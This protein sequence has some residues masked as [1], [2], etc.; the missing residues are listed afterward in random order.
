[1]D[2]I[3]VTVT[4]KASQECQKALILQGLSGK[5][6][7][8]IVV[9]IPQSALTELPIS[10][11]TNGNASLK[12][13]EKH[14]KHYDDR[15]IDFT[16][17]CGFECDCCGKIIDHDYVTSPIYTYDDVVSLVTANEARLNTIKNKI[18]QDKKQKQLIAEIKATT[19]QE[20]EK[21][22]VDKYSNALNQIAQV[23]VV[24]TNKTRVRTSQIHN[25]IK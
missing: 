15:I 18:E 13:T 7:Q 24:I 9:A 22:F 3:N 2:T 19:R 16:N 4:Y 1:M 17:H 25:I 11:D 6:E 20:V 10:I 14:Y 8:K 23:R 12:L 5:F 21:E